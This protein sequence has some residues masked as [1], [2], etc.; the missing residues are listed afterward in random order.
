MNIAATQ[1]TPSRESHTPGQP[2]PPRHQMTPPI[3]YFTICSFSLLYQHRR[4]HLHTP[5]G[6]PPSMPPRYGL[7]SSLSLNTPQPPHSIASRRS[8]YQLFFATPIATALYAAEI[9]HT[10]PRR[11]T[12]H[13]ER[14]LRLQSQPF[15]SRRQPLIT[16]N[17][18]PFH[19]RI[20][21]FH[22]HLERRFNITVYASHF[23]HISLLLSPYL[24]LHFR[25]TPGDSE[26]VCF[27][28][29]SELPL[30]RHTR[31]ADG[32]RRH[33]DTPQLSLSSRFVTSFHRSAA[34]ASFFF[35]SRRY[36][37]RQLRLYA[38]PVISDAAEP[39]R[40]RQPRVAAAVSR[41]SYRYSILR[42]AA[43]MRH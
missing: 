8:R 33:D 6:R 12:F 14:R 43:T 27:L 32:C 35:S 10:P 13:A 42:R 38:E 19:A 9:Y 2:P 5:S 41:L 36:A 25:H 22:V 3:E 18:T 20:I 29:A 30:F 39:Q 23:F 11:R 26:F 7:Q 4:R 28:S 15:P 16:A 17:I 31:H 40:P 34:S 1:D 24:R 37:I 21:I